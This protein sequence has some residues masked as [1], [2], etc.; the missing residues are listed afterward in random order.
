M[1]IY[2]KYFLNKCTVFRNSRKFCRRVKVYVRNTGNR[3]TMDIKKRDKSLF[4]YIQGEV[5][6]TCLSCL[7]AT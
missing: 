3:V 1:Y 4:L 7:A 5:S 2:I 6:R